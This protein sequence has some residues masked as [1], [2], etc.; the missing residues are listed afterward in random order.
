MQLFMHTLL[1]YCSLGK[2]YLCDSGYSNSDGF[3][4]PFKGV[5]YHLK[6]W[7]PGSQAPQTTEELFNLR[8]AKTRNVIERSFAPC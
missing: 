5:R 7:G 6:E 8:H 1:F 3:M 4:T 2:Y